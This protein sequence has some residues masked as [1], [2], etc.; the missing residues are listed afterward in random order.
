MD[1]ELAL[2]EKGPLFFILTMASWR[3]DA[4]TSSVLHTVGNMEL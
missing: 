4:K 1:M 2:E 3:N